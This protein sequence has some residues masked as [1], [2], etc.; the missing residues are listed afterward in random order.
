VTNDGGKKKLASNF[1]RFWC[2]GFIAM[3]ILYFLTAW[4][5]IRAPIASEYWV[6]EIRTIKLDIAR[7]FAG[8]RKIL[9]GGGS[10]V[11]FGVD[12]AYASRELHMPVINLGLNA[13]MHIDWILKAIDEAAEPGDIVIFQLDKTI[14][15]AQAFVGS[16]FRF[17]RTFFGSSFLGSTISSSFIVSL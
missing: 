6:N 5:C 3:M 2:G 8:Q 9:V 13:F 4:M 17:R 11:L 10:S 12:A 16:F 14:V 1:L 15:T 7:S